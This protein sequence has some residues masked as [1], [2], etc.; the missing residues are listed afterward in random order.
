MML[1]RT[2]SVKVLRL[3]GGALVFWGAIA[4]VIALAGMYQP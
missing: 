1:P 3:V 4:A 2:E